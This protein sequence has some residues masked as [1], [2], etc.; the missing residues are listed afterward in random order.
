MTELIWIVLATCTVNS[1]GHN[2]SQNYS[3]VTKSTRAVEVATWLNRNKWCGNVRVFTAIHSVD[4]TTATVVLPTICEI[5]GH[6]W[7]HFPMIHIRD[8]RQ[9][10][11]DKCKRCSVE[12][13]KPGEPFIYTA[14]RL[15]H[16]TTE[17]RGPVE[18]LR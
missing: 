1:F 6:E 4:V 9:V 13:E 8:G 17:Y 16:N 5:V 15:Q 18:Q 7:E 11:L 10:Y 12:R 3:Y 14:P 2:V